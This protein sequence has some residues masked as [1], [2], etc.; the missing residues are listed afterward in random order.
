M[1][2]I[3]ETQLVLDKIGLHQEII[4]N[5]SLLRKYVF[6]AKKIDPF[7]TEVASEVIKDYILGV[8]DLNKQKP[9]IFK[10]GK[11]MRIL[12][13]L[14]KSYARISLKDKIEKEDVERIL[15]IYDKHLKNIKVI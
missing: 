11:F 14:A 12:T 7:L 3:Y 5:D 9:E 13:I 6:L 10:E 8:K 15:K 2:D 4:L 1:K